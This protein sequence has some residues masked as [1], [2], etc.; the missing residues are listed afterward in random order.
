MTT[1][2]S[3]LLKDSATLTGIRAG[4][5]NST[6]TFWLFDN[7]ECSGE[8]LTEQA[9]TVLSAVGGSHT[10]TTTA[11]AVTEGS[12]YWF[13]SYSG[14]QYNDGFHSACGAEVTTVGATYDSQYLGRGA[15]LPTD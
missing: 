12:Y 7:D 13:V 8:L 4:G 6:V 5:G 9:I 1:E 2:I 10:V 11:V 3:W 15:L 14:N